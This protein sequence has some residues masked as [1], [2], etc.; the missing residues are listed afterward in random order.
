VGIHRWTYI[1]NSGNSDV[2]IYNPVGHLVNVIGGYGDKP[3]QLLGVSGVA[4]DSAG[5][6]FVSNTGAQTV[7]AYS[8]SGQYLYQWGSWGSQPGHFNGIA[9]LVTSPSTNQVYVADTLNNRIQVF[10]NAGGYIESVKT[11]DPTSLQWICAQHGSQKIL[12]VTDGFTGTLSQLSQL[13]YPDQFCP[14]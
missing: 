7:D 13:S 10:T 3:G 4:T 9:D 14:S 12:A 5:T 2:L 8:P 1:A 11:P 6:V